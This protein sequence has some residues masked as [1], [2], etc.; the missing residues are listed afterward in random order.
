MNSSEKKINSTASGY[1][2]GA[3]AYIMWGLLPFF[4][5]TLH[6]V[7]PLQIMVNRIIWCYIFLLIISMIRRKNSL[8]IF[9]SFK[10]FLSVFITGTVLSINWFTYIWAVNTERIVEASL[11]YY[12]N[13][14][15]CII[16]GMI[17]F[18]ERLTKM[19]TAAVISAATGVLYMTLDYGKFPTASII[20]AVSFGIYGLL[21]KYFA[22]DSIDGL[23]AETLSITPIAV[24]IMA[25][26][27]LR[28]ESALFSGSMRT[29]ILIM[30]SRNYNRI[31]SAAVCRRSKENPAFLIRL[32]SVYCSDI[33]AYYRY[34]LL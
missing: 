26:I 8:S 9:K 18:R 32:S 28:G 21:K 33:N 5:K 16:L 24:I 20:L 3:S 7:P 31:P 14:L 1:S 27:M 19:Q 17:F 34:I 29:D 13:P 25:S 2:F 23:M 15:V 11:G 22:F 4:W 6:H 10:L 30:M 12:I